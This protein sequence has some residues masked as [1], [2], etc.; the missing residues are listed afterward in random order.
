MRGSRDGGKAI[1]QRQSDWVSLS[2]DAWLLGLE[3]QA[4]IGLRM[5]KAA[6]G[7][8]EAQAE[9]ELMVAEKAKAAWDAHALL[10]SSILG[11]EADQ[12]PAR[13]IALY[14]GRVQAIQR[15]LSGR[16]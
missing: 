13:T 5:L 10:T 7:G 6:M 8:P 3:A 12:A 2:V 4:V 9:A 11:G 15:R 1:T 16:E 14:R